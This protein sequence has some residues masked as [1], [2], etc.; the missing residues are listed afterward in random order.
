LLRAISQA[1]TDFPLEVQKSSPSEPQ[2][3]RHIFGKAR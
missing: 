1:S 2:L 3:R